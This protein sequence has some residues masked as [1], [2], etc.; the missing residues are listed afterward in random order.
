MLIREK[1]EKAEKWK[2]WGRFR[3]RRQT[4]VRRGW[5]LGTGASSAHIRL[6]QKRCPISAPPTPSLSSLTP[7]PKKPLPFLPLFLF[8]CSNPGFLSLYPARLSSSTGSVEP[9]KITCRV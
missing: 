1:V 2:E 7:P 3:Q 9:E 8:P 4:Q 5:V 6:W